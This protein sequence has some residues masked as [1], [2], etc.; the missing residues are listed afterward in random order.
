MD[1][2]YMP[3]LLWAIGIIF[4]LGALAILRIEMVYRFRGRIIEKVYVRDDWVELHRE[5]DKV[6]FDDM[7]TRFWK[8][9]RSFFDREFLRKIDM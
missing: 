8:P 5:F 7:V 9:R 4:L 2:E 6:S 1:P 3:F